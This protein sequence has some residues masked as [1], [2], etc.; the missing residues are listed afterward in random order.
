MRYDRKLTLKSMKVVW[1]A[2]TGPHL[3]I[4]M[5]ANHQKKTKKPETEI[6]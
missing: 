4:N 5:F 1:D 6:K 3:D 2:F